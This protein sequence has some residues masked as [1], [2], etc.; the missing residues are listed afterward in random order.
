MLTSELRQDP[1][2]R[3]W[4]VV[5]PGRVQRPHDLARSR[6]TA[7]TVEGC[8]FCPGNESQTPGEVWRLD[9][10]DGGWQVRV[11]PNRYAILAADGS[12]RRSTDAAGFVSMPGLGRHE[13]VIESPDHSADLARANQASVRAVLEA[14][15]ARYVALRASGPGTGV[16]VIFRNHGTG[17]GT[18]LSHPHSQIVAAPV[19]PIQMRHRFDVA[20]QHYDDLGTSLYLDVLERELRDGRR[21]VLETP[22]FVVF[23]PF[24]SAVSFETWIVPREAQPSFDRADD[25]DLDDLAQ[26]L[27][28]VLA[29]LADELG[30]PDYNAII[31]SAPLA[32]EHREYFAWHVRI[33]P[34]LAIA[35]GF[36]LGS[37][38]AVNPSRPE[39]TAAALRLAV[40]RVPG[41]ARR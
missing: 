5:A 29:G 1:C 20:Q 19:V 33:V 39:D 2:T 31:Q 32:D 8:P 27:R 36:E 16:V 28:S 17:A 15:R 22:R 13:V 25:A 26:V 9:R 10:P 40:Q 12:P 24:A 7:S 14:Y 30:D 37:G 34:R 6:P 11:V 21:V 23:Q 41:R 18:S 38:M 35:A 4:V 3:D